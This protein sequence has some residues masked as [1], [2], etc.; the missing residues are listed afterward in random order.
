MEYVDIIDFFEKTYL[1]ADNKKELDYWNPLAA[2][3]SELIEQLIDKKIEK[4]VI[5]KDLKIS[6]REITKWQSLE[7]IPQY[8]QMAKV[9]AYFDHRLHLSLYGGYTVTL[10][11]KH[12]DDITQIAQKLNRDSKCLLEEKFIEFIEK[13]VEDHKEGRDA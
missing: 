3:T 1:E 13:F 5:A 9:A 8:D 11:T 6:M 4:K 12:H 7:V 2:F 10:P